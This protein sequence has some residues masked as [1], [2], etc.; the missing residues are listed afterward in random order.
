MKA[1]TEEFARQD[2]DEQQLWDELVELLAKAIPEDVGTE[3][4]ERSAMFALMGHDPEV[5][6]L[7]ETVSRIARERP[8][9]FLRA[10]LDED[11]QVTA[12]R[13]RLYGK[14]A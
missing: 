4:Q 1:G 8:A 11:N 6:D 14:W 13:R 5:H 7:H 3:E 9:G 10:K 12:A 2:E